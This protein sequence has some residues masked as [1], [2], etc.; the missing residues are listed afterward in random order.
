MRLSLTLVSAGFAAFALA[1]DIISPPV[2]VKLIQNEGSVVTVRFTNK[3]G[4]DVNF[5]KRANIL[6]PNPIQKV[7]VTSQSGQSAQL[8]E[9]PSMFLTISQERMYASSELTPESPRKICPKTH[10]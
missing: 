6:D 2:E 8:P 1:T 4:D 9:E 7:N 3:G 10:S 5:F